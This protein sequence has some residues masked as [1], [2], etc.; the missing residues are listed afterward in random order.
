MSSCAA[1]LTAAFIVT[2]GSSASAAHAAAMQPPLRPAPAVSSGSCTFKKTEYATANAFDESTSETFVN[3]REAGSVA[4][5]QNGTGCVA[6]TFF[7][8]AG[9]AA[10]G[11]H[12]GLQ[13]LLDGSACAPLLGGYIFADSEFSSHSVGFFCGADVAPGK[14]TIQ[15]QYH[16]GFGGNVQFF[17]R[18]LEVNHT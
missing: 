13:V 8:N 2:A 12:I 10:A 6:G 1:A 17:Q 11:D 4:F 9:S 3:L 16:S 14:H 15:V 18:T 7:A 5:T